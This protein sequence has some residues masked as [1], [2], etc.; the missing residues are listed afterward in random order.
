VN[1]ANPGDRILIGPGVYNESILI[2]VNRVHLIALEG[3]HSVVVDGTGLDANGIHILGADGVELRDLVVRNFAEFVGPGVVDFRVGILVESSE[4]CRITGGLAHSNGDG[5]VLRGAS[6]CLVRGN[7]ARNNIHN[8]FFLRNGSND[9]SV[10]GN[11]ALDNG[12]D[13]TVCPETV[14]AFS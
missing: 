12:P 3:L 14:G 9:N 6:H 5:I 4:N 10:R 1:A 2:T 8:G 11:V 13:R 7:I